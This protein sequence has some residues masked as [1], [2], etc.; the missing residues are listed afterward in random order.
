MADSSLSGME[1]LLVACKIS[2]ELGSSIKNRH[3]DGALQ[4]LCKGGKGILGF[5][6]GGGFIFCLST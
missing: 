1:P 4:M 5:S 3:P 2:G 6:D